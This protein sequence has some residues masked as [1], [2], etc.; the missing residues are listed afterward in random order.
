MAASLLW[1][2]P[3]EAAGLVVRG[4]RSQSLRVAAVEGPME[5][6]VSVQGGP[7]AEVTQVSTGRQGDVFPTTEENP[8]L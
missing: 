3:F 7:P 6:D 1:G 8:L 2:S 5:G 4:T